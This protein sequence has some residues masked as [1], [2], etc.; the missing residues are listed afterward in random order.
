[1]SDI[2][3][4][5]YFLNYINVFVT[6]FVEFSLTYISIHTLYEVIGN[7]QWKKKLKFNVYFL[8]FGK[9]ILVF[10]FLDVLVE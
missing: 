1:M 9:E 7:F 8:V 2:P 3:G 4:M 6:S 10:I 5:I